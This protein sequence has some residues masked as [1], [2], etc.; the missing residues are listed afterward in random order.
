MPRTGENIQKN[1]ISKER[2]R[3]EKHTHTYMLI[4]ICIHIYMP[5]YVSQQLSKSENKKRN[6]FLKIGIFKQTLYQIR[7]WDGK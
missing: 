1:R 6:Y 7:N 4:Y 5:I 3:I 2:I